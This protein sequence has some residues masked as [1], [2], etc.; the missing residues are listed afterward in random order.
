MGRPPRRCPMC[1][2]RR[3][4]RRIEA[5]R[6][7]YSPAAALIAHALLGTPGLAAGA[8]GRRREA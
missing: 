6:D 2:A 8:T 1:G 5:Y 3:G 4:W 7:G